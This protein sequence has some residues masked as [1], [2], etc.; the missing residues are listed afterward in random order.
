MK[1]EKFHII[2]VKLLQ[3]RMQMDI[4]EKQENFRNWGWKVSTI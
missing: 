4:F 2:I 1:A 3:L